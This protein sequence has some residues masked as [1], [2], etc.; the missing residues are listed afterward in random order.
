MLKD[1]NIKDQFVYPSK[2][3]KAYRHKYNRVIFAHSLNA[4]RL[5]YKRL[6]FT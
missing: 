1:W 4:Y 5:K 6:M 3:V 2:Q